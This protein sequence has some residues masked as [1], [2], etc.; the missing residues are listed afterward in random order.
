M[1]ATIFTAQ[2][3][4]ATPSDAPIACYNAATSRLSS[5]YG[6]QLC[7]GAT[8]AAPAECYIQ[9]VDRGNFTDYDA[10]RLC[11][12]ATSTAPATCA[13]QIDEETGADENTQIQYCGFNAYLWPQSAQS[14]PACASRASDE[15]G[16]SDYDSLRLC[17]GS[18]GTGAADCFLEGRGNTDLADSQ[19][20]TLC[21]PYVATY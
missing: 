5:A 12:L 17:H 10:V 2:L 13:A 7:T 6:V 21:A 14:D 18:V 11:R 1:L 19:L 16:L 3:V 8:S 15:A 20:I 9:A 4:A